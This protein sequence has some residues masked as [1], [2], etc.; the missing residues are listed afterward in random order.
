MTVE[1]LVLRLELSSGLGDIDGT[2]R[3][4]NSDTPDLARMM[5]LEFI[6]KRHSLGSET[7]GCHRGQCLLTECVEP[8]IDIGR[9]KSIERTGKHPGEVLADIG[10]QHANSAQRSSVARHIDLVTTQT[11]PDRG[12]VHWAS[13]TSRHQSEA[14]R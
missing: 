9:W 10:V 4:P 14:A 11:R 7:L 12:T 1:P 13:A 2:L 6:T 3:D 8:A 5:Q